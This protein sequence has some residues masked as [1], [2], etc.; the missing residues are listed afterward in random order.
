MW[1]SGE[2]LYLKIELDSAFKSIEA[3][4]GLEDTENTVI[5]RPLHM[6]IEDPIHRRC[7]K[8]PQAI[9]ASILERSLFK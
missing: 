1:R 5:L 4:M 3:K 9:A 2:I 6:V 8:L 7:P